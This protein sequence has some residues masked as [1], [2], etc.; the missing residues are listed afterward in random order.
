MNTS[1]VKNDIQSYNSFSYHMLSLVACNCFFREPFYRLYLL[2]IILLL[3]KHRY[4]SMSLKK[5][6]W[7]HLYLCDIIDGAL[8]FISILMVQIFEIHKLQYFSIF[9]KMLHFTFEQPL[10]ITKIYKFP[11][12]TLHSIVFNKMLLLI[13]D[14]KKTISN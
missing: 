5:Q 10:N 8:Q 12:T 4:Y 6:T 13:K 9:F 1:F 3:D 7:P 11:Q 14:N 2:I